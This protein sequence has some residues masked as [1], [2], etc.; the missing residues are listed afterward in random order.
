VGVTEWKL[1]LAAHS[2]VAP[3][4]SGGSQRPT[5]HNSSRRVR[6]K[7]PAADHTK[8]S[9]A[10]R[11]SGAEAPAQVRQAAEGSAPFALFDTRGGQTRRSIRVRTRAPP[12]RGVLHGAQ[13]SLTFTSG[14]RIL[15]P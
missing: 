6:P 15:M 13:T 12:H 2:V 11:E 4:F 1:V 10:E 5:C 7:R 3:S 14:R 9:M 8:C